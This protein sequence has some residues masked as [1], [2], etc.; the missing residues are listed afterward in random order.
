[1]AIDQ[2]ARHRTFDVANA[3]D[4]VTFTLNYSVPN[5]EHDPELEGS[6]PRV[7]QSQLFTCVSV[8]PAGVL[9]DMV[10]AQDS[11]GGRSAQALTDFVNGVLIDAD[12]ERFAT[13]VHDKDVA[14]PI[15]VLGQIVA[16]LAEEYAGRPT[17]PPTP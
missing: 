11:S 15:E 10:A 4:A 16:W 3:T 5:P 13:L 12:L 9:L 2:P 8:A 7:Q 14:I 6:Q 17:Q 1:M